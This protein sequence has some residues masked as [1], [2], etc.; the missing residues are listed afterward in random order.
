MSKKVKI[1]CISAGAV[2][3]AGLIAVIVVLAVRNHNA[4]YQNSALQEQILGGDPEGIEDIDEEET[5]KNTIINSAYSGM[6]GSNLTWEFEPETFTLTVNG[7]GDMVDK[8]D[9]DIRPSFYSLYDDKIHHI[10]IG[11]EVTSIASHAFADLPYLET[12]EFGKKLKSIGTYAFSGCGY[13]ISTGLNKIVCN[14]ALEIIEVNAFYSSDNIMELTLSKNYHATEESP[15]YGI[16]RQGFEAKITVPQANPWYTSVDG[17][18]YNKDKT[19]LLYCCKGNEQDWVIPESVKVIGERAFSEN[20]LNTLTIPG[21]VQKIADGAITGISIKKL[22][23]NEGIKEVGFIDA[24]EIGELVISDS[25]TRIDAETFNHVDTI[26]FSKNSA[27]LTTGADGFI[28]TKDMKTL[29]RIPE[30][31]IEKKYKSGLYEDELIRTELIIPKGVVHIAA[32]ATKGLGYYWNKIELPESVASIGSN[33]FDGLQLTENYT[34]KLPSNLK[35]IGAECF[36]ECTLYALAIPK[37]VKKIG[38]SF[39]KDTN[40][41]RYDEE[42]DEYIEQKTKLIVESKDAWQA[43]EYYG[44]EED[45][46]SIEIVFSE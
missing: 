32:R 10:I 20:K 21:S 12:V 33:N 45:F 41:S 9:Y 3:L 36:Q 44:L 15:I 17:C 40:N 24:E 19:E 11:D 25:V 26:T 28:Y 34:F 8:F 4:Q 31:A 35:T 27:A 13:E 43:I 29:V 39:L 18:V 1:I 37:S 6:I 7:K 22:V 2:L 23:L 30:E 16:F 5:I 38:H 14:E 42:K 46:D